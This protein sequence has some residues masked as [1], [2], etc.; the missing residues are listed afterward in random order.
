VLVIL[1]TNTLGAIL[2]LLIGRSRR[3]MTT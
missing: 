2:Y 1:L 3:A